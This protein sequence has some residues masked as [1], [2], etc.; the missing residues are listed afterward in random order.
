MRRP[1]VSPPQIDEILD[2]LRR[3]ILSLMEGR[4]G[5]GAFLSMHE[6]MG[7]LDE[8]VRELKDA[9]HEGSVVGFDEEM[10][11]VAVAAVF[12]VASQRTGAFLERD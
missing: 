3:R 8:E 2:E 1:P 7:A 11:D 12:S 6:C 4:K 9:V 5:N 10:L